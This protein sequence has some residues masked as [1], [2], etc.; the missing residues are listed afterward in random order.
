MH[1][2]ATGL[3]QLHGVGIAHQ[4][5]KPSNVLVFEKEPTSVSKVADLG[6]SS[7]RDG[8]SPYEHVKWAGDI[9][10]APPE[11]LYSQIDVD[12]NNRRI[13]TDLYL[14]GSMVSFIFTNTTAFAALRQ[15]LAL[16]HDPS[17]WGASY[18]EVLPYVR[19]AFNL[20]ATAFEQELPKSL[21]RDLV[22]IYLQLCE[23]DP[24][25][26]GP[27]GQ[28]INKVSLM[29]FVSRFDTLA[30]KAAAGKYKE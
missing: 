30:C 27:P 5:L 13:A 3:M 8:S 7:S 24:L 9:T 15:N 6:N 22:P 2:I 23:P 12:W 25:R 29:R 26:R 11:I 19:T 18:Q 28:A 20:A 1:H 4:D 14:L 16:E 17:N 21:A 10:Y